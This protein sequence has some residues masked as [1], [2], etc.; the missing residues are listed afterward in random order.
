M[1]AEAQEF[2]F[3]VKMGDI[4]IHFPEYRKRALDIGERLGVLRDYPVSK[5]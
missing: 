2:L 5:G 3:G 1:F 4:G